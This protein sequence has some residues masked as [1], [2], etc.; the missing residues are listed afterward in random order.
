MTKDALY[1]IAESK[2]TTKYIKEFEIYRDL[3]ERKETLNSA[4]KRIDKIYGYNMGKRRLY[5]RNSVR[6]IVNDILL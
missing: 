2:M 4:F 3:K 6:Y 5:A 1:F